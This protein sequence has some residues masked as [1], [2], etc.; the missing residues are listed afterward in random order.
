M[1]SKGRLKNAYHTEVD[2]VSAMKLAR[3]R[4]GGGFWCPGG[5]S[6]PKDLQNISPA[7]NL[8]WK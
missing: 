2:K 1:V 5:T 4:W 6:L 8:R 7:R 3:L